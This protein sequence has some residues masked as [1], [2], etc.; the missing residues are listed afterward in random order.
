MV[1][2]T[3]GPEAQFDLPSTPAVAEA[4]REVGAEVLKEFS[5]YD[6]P[7][8]VTAIEIKRGGAW[9]E[10]ARDEE[11]RSAHKTEIELGDEGWA[12]LMSAAYSQ[13]RAATNGVVDGHQFE[14]QQVAWGGGARWTVEVRFNGGED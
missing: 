6:G 5:H 12:R 13:L 4:F 7:Q 10:F 2:S 11:D 1:A 14:I 8:T 9:V 3:Y